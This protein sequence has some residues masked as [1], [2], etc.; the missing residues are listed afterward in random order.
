[1]DQAST[2]PG[3]DNPTGGGIGIDRDAIISDVLR[4][5]LARLDLANGL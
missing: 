1:M 5:H 2:A 3:A 4:H